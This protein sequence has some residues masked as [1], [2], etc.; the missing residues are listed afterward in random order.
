M[1]GITTT[2]TTTQPITSVN[3]TPWRGVTGVFDPDGI[4]PAALGEAPPP[5]GDARFRGQGSPL[6]RDASGRWTFVGELYLDNGPDLRTTLGLTEDVPDG[7][8]FVEL[9]ARQGVDGLLQASGMF[10]G[11]AFDRQAGPALLVAGRRRRAHAVLLRR[12]QARLVRL[13]SRRLGAD[14]ADAAPD[15]SDGLAQLPHVRFCAWD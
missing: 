10:A 9:I 14:G 8:A 4:N 5:D 13:P 7:I 12:G 3:P 2:E 6:W 1:I 11:A 15:V